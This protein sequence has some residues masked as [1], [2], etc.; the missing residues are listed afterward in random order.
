MA[1]H[2]EIITVL[3]RKGQ[4]KSYFAG[5]LLEQRLDKRFVILDYGMEHVGFAYA[6]P[7]S[8]IVPV[9]G[10][11]QGRINWL[12]LLEDYYGLVVVPYKITDLQ[13]TVE[14]NKLMHAIMEVENRRILFEEVHNIAPVQGIMPGFSRI[15]SQGRKHRI[16]IIACSLRPADVS[17]ALLAQSDEFYLFNVTEPN[18][19]KY[20]ERCGLPVT[21]L[22]HL[23]ARVAIR[24]NGQAG[25]YKLVRAPDRRIPHYG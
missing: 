21:D 2:S 6:H 3:G 22:P 11:N 1:I 17:K 19:L 4:G 25:V 15:V 12:S 23:K 5:A 18:A 8:V 16:D 24:Y 10:E 7:N 13:F 14:A 20:L 9:T